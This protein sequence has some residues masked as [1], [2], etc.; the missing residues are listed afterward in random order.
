[1]R[2]KFKYVLS[3]P[4]LPLGGTIFILYKKGQGTL[5]EMVCLCA[6]E[7]LTVNK[8]L[9]ENFFLPN[10]ENKLSRRNYQQSIH[11]MTPLL[12]VTQTVCF[13]KQL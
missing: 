10:W 2:G 13:P 8:I 6:I 7:Q 11:L 1:M 4:E 5:K 9:Q 12:A 3:T